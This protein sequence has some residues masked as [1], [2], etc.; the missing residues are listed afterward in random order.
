MRDFERGG[1]RFQFPLI[2]KARVDEDEALTLFRMLAFPF[3]LNGKARVD[4]PDVVVEEEEPKKCFVSIPSERE[5]TCRRTDD[6][7]NAG[8][9][10]KVSIPSERE[11]TCR[12]SSKRVG[13]A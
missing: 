5:S 9:A 1:G 2:R 13:S 7:A 8:K 3:R 12:R 4:T 6:K 11:S 10:D